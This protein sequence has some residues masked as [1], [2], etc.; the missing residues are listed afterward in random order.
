MNKHFLPGV[1]LACFVCLP[2]LAVAVEAPPMTYSETLPQSAFQT[3]DADAAVR[4]L[5]KAN[6][7]VPVI[8]KAAMENGVSPDAII[9]ALL[10]AGISPE[11]VVLQCLQGPMPFKNVLA[12]LKNRGIPPDVVLARLIKW[13]IGIA[14]IYDTC[15]FM[16][17]NGFS[18]ADI[19]TILKD[20]G[21]DRELVIQVVRWFEIPPATVIAVYQSQLDYFGHVFNRHSLPQPALLS[22]GVARITIKERGP[23]ISPMKP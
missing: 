5:L 9:G 8:I 21:A 19:L 22:I 14:G 23:V 2:V 7:P 16:L 3:G 11:K 17:K 15:D 1:I 13:E 10:A 12:A 4:M 6:V 20:T 18:Q